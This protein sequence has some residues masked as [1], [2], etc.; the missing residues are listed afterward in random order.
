MCVSKHECT[1]FAAWSNCKSLQTYRWYGRSRVLRCRSMIR[2]RQENRDSGSRM[3]SNTG[4]NQQEETVAQTWP[5]RSF[6]LDDNADSK[7]SGLTGH[8]H[9]G[10]TNFIAIHRIVAKTLHSSPKR[11]NLLVTR[12]KKVQGS[13]AGVLKISLASLEKAQ[14]TWDARWV[15]TIALHETDW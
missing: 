7:V 15:T 6:R 10:S 11:S 1:S 14:K 4:L 2:Y 8:R 12:E 5:W 9:G 3:M 13:N